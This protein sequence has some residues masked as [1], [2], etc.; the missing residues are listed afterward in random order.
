M[1][2]LQKFISW[3]KPILTDSGGF[4]VW[5][6]SKLKNINEDGVNFKSHIDGKEIFLTPEKAMQIQFDLNSDIS[7]FR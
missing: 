7:G 1:G 6:L 2:G 3:N 4:Q 5:S